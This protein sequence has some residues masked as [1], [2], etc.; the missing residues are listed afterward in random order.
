[1]GGVGV[2]GQGVVDVCVVD[3]CGAVGGSVSRAAD[4]GVDAQPIVR[5]GSCQGVWVQCD[6]D[7]VDALWVALDCAQVAVAEKCGSRGPLLGRVLEC[8][9]VFGHV[10]GT[11]RPSGH[12]T[13]ASLFLDDDDEYTGTRLYCQSCQSSGC[14]SGLFFGTKV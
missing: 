11:R 10:C 14:G 4:L 7:A 9:L 12:R 5:V 8:S 6:L 2:D 3:V 1:M 13:F